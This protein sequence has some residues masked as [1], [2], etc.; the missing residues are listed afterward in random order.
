MGIN[1]SWTNAK[2][3]FSAQTLSSWPYILCLLKCKVKSIKGIFVVFPVISTSCVTDHQVGFRLRKNWVGPRN[4]SQ[5]LRSAR[6]CDVI[7]KLVPLLCDAGICITMRCFLPEVESTYL[8][9]HSLKSYDIT[10]WKMQEHTTCESSHLPLI[11]ST[12]IRRSNRWCKCWWLN[13]GKF[14]RKSTIMKL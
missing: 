7:K 2:S 4:S 10:S 12:W 13:H 6:L 11:L 1:D 14:S 3:C 8:R 5:T 9:S